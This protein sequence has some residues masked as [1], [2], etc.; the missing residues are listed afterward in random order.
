MNF[1]FIYSICA[2]LFLAS[3]STTKVNRN[4]IDGEKTKSE[5][6]VIEAK[7]QIGSPYKYG[8]ETPTGFDCSGLVQYVYFLVGIELPRV[9]RFQAHQGEKITIKA[10]KKGDLLFFGSNRQVTHVGIVISRSN[11][12]PVMIHSSSSKGV[13]QTNLANSGYWT[14]RFLYATRVI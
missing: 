11:G 3:C 8:G 13:I 10:A 2:C 5:M 14:R 6:I 9:S 12:F 1:K 4:T 7:R